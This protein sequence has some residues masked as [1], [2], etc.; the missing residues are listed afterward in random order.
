MISTVSAIQRKKKVLIC[1]THPYQFNGY[2]KVMY[3]LCYE[4]SKYTDIKLY[5]FAFQNFFKNENHKRERSLDES[6]EIYDAYENESPKGKGFG[7]SLIQ[8]YIMKT[9]PDIIIIYN[10]LVVITSLLKK[11]KEIQHTTPPKYKIVPYIDLVY[12]NEKN[13]LIKV[14]NDNVD[15]GIMFT[16]YWKRCITKQGFT[17]PLDVLEHGFN[18][19]NYYKIPKKVAR[20]FLGIDQDAF[21]IVNL[22]R[23]QPRKRWDLCIMAYVKFIS[24]RLHENIKLLIGTSTNGGWDLLDVMISEC[25]KND[26]K[27]DDFKKHII[28]I[29]NPQKISDNEVN[30]M[31]NVGDVGINTCDGEGFGLCNFEQAG[32]GVPQ[33][34]PGIGGFLDYFTNDNAIVIQ[35]KWSYYC[36]NSRD[37]VSGE[38]EVCS[39]DDYISAMDFYYTNRSLLE[40]HGA[41]AREDILSK[42]KWPVLAE[43]FHNVIC[44]HVVICEDE[45][46]NTVSYIS[47]HICA[48]DVEGIDIDSLIESHL[49]CK[50]SDAMETNADLITASKLIKNTNPVKNL[51]DIH[52]DDETHVTLPVKN[53]EVDDDDDD[54]EDIIII[55]GGG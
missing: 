14:I 16:E 6:V 2:S 17:K 9:D 45:P 30:I 31:Y 32:V 54:D 55:E 34:V 10:D 5:I 46:V 53:S 3:E 11:I 39:V 40:K 8:D 12:K 36:D 29:Q 7:E 43:K 44:K 48:D 41:K 52:D 27:F 20:I 33:I 37:F 42:Y 23:N 49:K 19:S 47:T 22:N 25:R 35:P 26:I 13:N 38:A 15:G 28:L 21:V 1:G 51:D 24:K 50:Q 18:S 4:L